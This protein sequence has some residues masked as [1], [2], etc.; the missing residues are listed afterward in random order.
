MTKA[1]IDS[2]R[3]S[4]P[5]TSLPQTIQDA[6]LITRNFNIRYLWIH[7]ICIIQDDERDK[8]AEIRGMGAIY[9]QS[10]LTI[11]AMISET[12]Y[13]KF[14]KKSVPQRGSLFSDSL[15]QWNIRKN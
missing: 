13:Q 7:A 4:I 12:A 14:I 2:M 11:A 15:T 9:K 6:I 10:T 5:M 3:L 8:V 1:T